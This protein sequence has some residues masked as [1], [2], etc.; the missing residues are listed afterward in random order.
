MKAMRAETLSEAMLFNSIYKLVELIKNKYSSTYA[1]TN[2]LFCEDGIESIEKI[3]KFKRPALKEEYLAA[4]SIGSNRKYSFCWHVQGETT[5]YSE[6]HL[7]IT[8]NDNC[9]TEYDFVE[10]L[11]DEDAIPL[12]NETIKNN[13][14]FTMDIVEK[15]TN[16]VNAM[17][18]L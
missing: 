10:L 18:R 17:L 16:S 9:D 2:I 12:V 13:L 15:I 6:Y 7:T 11:I 14:S 3:Y 4:M 8:Q 1:V 5:E